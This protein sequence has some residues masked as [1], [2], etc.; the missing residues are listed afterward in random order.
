MSYVILTYT[1][2]S[3][4]TVKNTTDLFVGVSQMLHSWTICKLNNYNILRAWKEVPSMVAM[5][6]LEA[7]QSV[8]SSPSNLSGLHP[9]QGNYW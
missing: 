7:S 3:V 5:R 4:R 8:Y 9:V 2:M 1:E 6:I